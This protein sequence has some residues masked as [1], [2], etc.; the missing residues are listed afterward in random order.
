MDCRRDDLGQGPENPHD[1]P[2]LIYLPELPFSRKSSL[3]AYRRSQEEQVLL[4]RRGEGLLDKD[5]NYVA[6]SVAKMHSVISNLAGSEI[7]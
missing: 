2:H 1:T 3:R 4:G 6:N 7:I 5:G